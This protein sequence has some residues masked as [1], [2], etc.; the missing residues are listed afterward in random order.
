MN[1][2]I[3]R[4]KLENMKY[5]ERNESLEKKIYENEVRL[6]NFDGRIENQ[7]REMNVLEKEKD[8]EIKEWKNK[9]ER[10]KRENEDLDYELNRVKKMA[11]A[12]E[13]S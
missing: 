12:E 11:T 2:Q 10:L 1:E 6:S 8:L 7:K 9:F 3:N 13:H 4:E 5:R